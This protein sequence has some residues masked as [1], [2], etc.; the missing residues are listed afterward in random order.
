MLWLFKQ[1]PNGVNT[2]YYDTMLYLVYYVM[3]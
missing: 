3:L 1:T 2:E